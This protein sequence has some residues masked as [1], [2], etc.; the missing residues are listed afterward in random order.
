MNTHTTTKEK[1]MTDTITLAEAIAHTGTDV[2][3]YLDRE[4]SVPVVTRAACQGDVSILRVTTQAA[5][6]PLPK[7]LAVV[8][9]ES[10]GNT[11]ALHP[12]GECYFDPAVVR[13]DSLVLGT[14]TVAEGSTALLSH[15]EH[16]YLSI[17][18]GT[19]RIGRQREWAGEWALVAD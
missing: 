13:E 2:L 6:K 4:V 5:T 15:P 3:D 10:G 12:D 19:Y 9:G 11:H 8:R 1:T 14:L 18:P 7:Y 16:G 17:A